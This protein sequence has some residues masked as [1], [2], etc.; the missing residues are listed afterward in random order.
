[1]RLLLIAEPSPGGI[2]ANC[3]CANHTRLAVATP[4]DNAYPEVMC[5][6]GAERLI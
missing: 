1:M 2:A 6:A 5:A 3:H 4:E